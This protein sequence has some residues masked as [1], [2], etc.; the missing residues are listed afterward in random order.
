MGRG[1]GWGGERG[2]YN[3]NN[4]KGA[5]GGVNMLSRSPS[6]SNGQPL[7]VTHSYNSCSEDNSILCSCFVLWWMLYG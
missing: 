5:G 2:K 1:Q 3:Y 6:S 7:Y 4:F